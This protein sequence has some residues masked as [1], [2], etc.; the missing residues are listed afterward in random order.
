MGQVS[1]ENPCVGGSGYLNPK[2]LASDPFI[3]FGSYFKG[4]KVADVDEFD[5]LVVID[6]QGGQYSQGGKV[7]GHGLGSA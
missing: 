5:V 4:T 3:Y 1:A 6:S 2:L 7:I